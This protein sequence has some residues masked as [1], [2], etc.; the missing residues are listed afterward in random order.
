LGDARRRLE[1]PKSEI[2]NPK[3][4]NSGSSVSELGFRVGILGQVAQL[5]AH[6]KV[7]GAASPGL[8][9]FAVGIAVL[10]IVLF[11]PP[12]RQDPSYHSFA[13]QREFWSVP[14][15]LNVV[16]NLPFFVVGLMGLQFVLVQGKESGTF[17]DGAERWPFLVLFA[18]VGLTALG[19]GYYHWAP[20]NDR[21]VWDRLPMAISFMAFFASMIAERIR[22][23]AGVWL[24]GPLV[25]L[26]IGSV[27]NW[28]QTDDLRLYGVVQFYPLVII[29]IMLCLCPPRY[30]GTGYIWG[31][32]GWYV[33]AKILEL[34]TMDHGIFALGQTVSGH[35]LKH[36]AASAGAFWVYLYVRRRRPAEAIGA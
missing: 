26:G 18:G 3:A 27:V 24:L 4:E 36:L 12:L 7:Q 19:S 11:L 10:G 5:V 29:P 33:L 25:L 21:L 14:N 16:S 6:M 13:D 9:F 1:N 20:D 17:L 2:R 34:H 22:V 31:V 23:E 35:T 32:L 28:R 15:F 30:E 8:I